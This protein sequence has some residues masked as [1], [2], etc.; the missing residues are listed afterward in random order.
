MR[1]HVLG[2]NLKRKRAFEGYEGYEA[3]LKEKRIKQEHIDSLKSSLKKIADENH[4]VGFLQLLSSSTETG[5]KRRVCQ[6]VRL[7]KK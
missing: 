4:D 5:E 7:L 1:K 6:T 2:R 3:L